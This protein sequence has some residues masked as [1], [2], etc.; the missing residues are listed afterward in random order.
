L[1]KPTKSLNISDLIKTPD[2][3]TMV[4][5]IFNNKLK[6]KLK[7]L[8]MDEITRGSYFDKKEVKVT[9]VGLNI[10]RGFKFTLCKLIKGLTLQIDV[11]SKVIRSASLL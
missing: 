8:N 4:F 5:Q 7:N 2:G 11:C 10:L 6:A 3:L 1:V 9:E